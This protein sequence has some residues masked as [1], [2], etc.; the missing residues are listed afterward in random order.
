MILCCLDYL[1]DNPR[2]PE[3][4]TAGVLTMVFT[5]AEVKYL[6]DAGGICPTCML[7]L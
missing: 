4:A 3:S 1:A 2:I 5:I 7:A 6:T